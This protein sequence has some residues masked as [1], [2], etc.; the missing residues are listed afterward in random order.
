MSIDE[1][2]SELHKLNRTEKLQAIQI[3]VHD[4]AAAEDALLKP[5]ETYTIWSPHDSYGAAQTMLDALE[6]E[7]EKQGQ[8]G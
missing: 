8:H 1:L 7:K 3:L 6:K 2:V 5:G 4:L